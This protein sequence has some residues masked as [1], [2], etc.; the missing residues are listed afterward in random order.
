MITE[1]TPSL[2]GF[3]YLRE[4]RPQV[5][6]G[7]LASEEE[8]VPLVPEHQ[9]GVVQ[10]HLEEDGESVQRGEDEALHVSL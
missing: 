8:W 7:S 10:E 5:R 9:R 3:K 6:R 4:T 2:E 1:T